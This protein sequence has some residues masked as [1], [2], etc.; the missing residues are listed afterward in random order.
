MWENHTRP[1]AAAPAS[2][3][4]PC[5]WLYPFPLP[6]LLRLEESR[7]REIRGSQIALIFQEPG[8]A[9]NP[10]MKCR[11]SGCGEVIRAHTNWDRNRCRQEEAET[12]LAS[13]RLSDVGRTFPPTPTS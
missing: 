12:G 8:L 5:G 3:R 6:G 1:F 13:V 11:G 9:L 10:V 4:R 2:D 7:L